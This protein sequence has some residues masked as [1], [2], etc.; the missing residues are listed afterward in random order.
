MHEEPASSHS[1]AVA[2]VREPDEDVEPLDTRRV[3]IGTGLF[4]VGLVAA[5]AAIGYF[6]REPLRAISERFVETLGGPGIAVGYFLPDAFTVPIPNDAFGWF[7]LE[8]GV[9][10][11]EVVMWGT[12]GSLIGGSVGY[13]IGAKLRQTRIVARFMR[14]RGRRLEAMVRRY[15]VQVVAVAA[16]TPLPYSLSAWAAG[17]VKMPYSHFFATS[18]LRVIR[19][20]GSLYLIRLGLWSVGA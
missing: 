7:G 4:I 8:G 1:A 16:I 12:G 6:F 5:A 15:G 18:L 13:L 14:G 10:F 20:A 11:W 3:L 2:E 9:P 17:A 19:V